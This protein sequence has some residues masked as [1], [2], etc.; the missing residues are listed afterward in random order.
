MKYLYL[1]LNWVFGVLFLLAG[2]LSLVESPL[3]GLSLIAAAALLL[4]PVR[5]FVYSKTN[6]DFPVKARA[7]SIFILFMAFGFFVGQA[8]E[9]KEQELAAQQAQEKAEKAAQLRQDNIDYF[10][11]N[12]EQIM[13][14]VKSAITGK[15]Y[16]AA[17]S[18]SNKYLVSGDK[19]L[20][21][22]NTQAKNELSA[23][24]KAKKTEKLLAE[25]KSVPTEKFEKNRG[26]YQQLLNM[27]P[28]SE[29]YK[30]KVAFYVGKIKEEKQKKIAAEA[31]KKK[32]E[33]QFSAWDG[34]HRNLER[35]IKESMNDPDSY[36]H[37]KTV[38]WDRGDYLIVKTTFRGKNA[39]GGVVKN[40]VTA[41]V[42]LDGQVL[43]ILSQN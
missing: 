5:N 16:Q 25:L 27:H 4:P 19:E 34:S 12:R 14:R 22:L 37:V 20:G 8:Q 24:Q 17:I 18:Q 3:A 10:N 21:Q 23:I 36:E 33:S 41:K 30:N 38:Y 39:F 9:R 13:S 7:I 1:T 40:S 42:S 43:Q 29:L 28:D 26:L 35:V 31:R 32:I 6:K 11:A 2:V 15:D